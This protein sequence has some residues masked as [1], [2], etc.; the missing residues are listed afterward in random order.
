MRD[1]PG[2]LCAAYR[3]QDVISQANLIRGFV[4]RLIGDLSQAGLHQ[5]N[6]LM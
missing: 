3:Q 6:G 2:N 4:V 1:S 5:T